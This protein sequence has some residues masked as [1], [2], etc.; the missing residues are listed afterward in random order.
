MSIRANSHA[1]GRN[2]SRT[3]LRAAT[4]SLAALALAGCSSLSD[5]NPFSKETVLPGERE[6][7]FDNAV[8]GGEE[9]NKTASIGSASSV[10]W[11]Q[12]GGD[13]GNNSGNVAASISGGRAWRASVGGSG[14]GM[15]SG[16]VRIAARPVSDNGRIFVYNQNGDVT[17]LSTNGG[18][19]WR[20]SLRPEGESGVASGGGVAV[21][22]GR[23]FVATGYSQ[24]V[25]LDAS[26]G[27]V[28]WT[29]SINAPARQAPA[30]AGG[31]VVAVTQT[32]EVHAAAQDDGAERW[33][34]AG[35]AES[36]G[37][38]AF[39]NPAI[40]S[41]TV[42]VP[43]TSGEVMA[44]DMKNGEPKWVEGVTRSYRTRAVSGFTDV[45]ASPVVNGDMVFASG[46]S[47]R[48]VAS[49]LRN[50]ER[51]W[52]QD[53]GSLHTPIVSGGSVFLIDIEDRMVALER[54]TGKPLWR[55]VLPNVEGKK[56]SRIN[57]AGPVLANGVLVAASSD[58][59]LVRVDA[60]SGRVLGVSQTSEDIYVT[61]IIAGG[62]MVT[63]TSKG[64]VVAFN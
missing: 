20:R 38:L 57:W 22:G 42:I 19:L 8:P 25:A 52:E 45:S 39:A 13:A 53:V 54:S 23:V 12:G 60:T 27:A 37:L 59:R 10:E 43:F 24:L 16:T 48:L 4:L 32:G 47:G 64:D 49:R 46:V 29:K 14:G 41:G 30:A 36:S 61:P 51:V 28:L 3:F 55:T 7:L 34:Y 5:L 31:T 33:T 56:K 62:R 35:I 26:S 18:R 6:A 44:L 2:G 15:F 63:I 58:G 11:R 50:G 9:G 40:S 17:A 21:D 1:F